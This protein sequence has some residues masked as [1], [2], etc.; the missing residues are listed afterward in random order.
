MNDLKTSLGLLRSALIYRFKP[1]GRRRLVHFYRPFVRPGALC[2][3]VGAHLGSRS[4]ALLALGAR[5]VALEPQPACAADLERRLGGRPGFTLCAMAAGAAPGRA[6]LH[7]NRLNPTISTLAP[8]AWRRAMGAAARGRERWDRTLAIEVTTLDRLIA[9]HGLPDFCKIDVEGFE[10][11]VLCGLSHPIPLL[12]FEF[13]SFE[14]QR[15]AA[16]LRRLQTLGP[17]RFNLS[18]RER[19]RLEQTDWIDARRLEALL[20]GFSGQILSGDIYARLE[21]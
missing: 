18:L 19:Q 4:E 7:L 14:P 3:D 6:T 16:C 17:Y 11:E 12:S 5:V 21:G 8:A 9:E 20:K 10:E 1:L 13:I 2:F 15:S